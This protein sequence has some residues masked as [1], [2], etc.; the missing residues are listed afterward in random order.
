MMGP[1]KEMEWFFLEIKVKYKLSVDD[2]I[3]KI[4]YLFTVFTSVGVQKVMLE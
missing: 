1:T 3:D 2:T 4:P